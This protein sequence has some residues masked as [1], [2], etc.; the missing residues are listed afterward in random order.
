MMTS[1]EQHILVGVFTFDN[2]RK[3]FVGLTLSSITTRQSLSHFDKQVQ[4]SIGTDQII[5]L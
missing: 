1:L 5:L 3:N 2:G 4:C